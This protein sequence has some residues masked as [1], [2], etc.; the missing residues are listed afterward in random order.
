MLSPL[1]YGNHI[2][3][4][5]VDE[6]AVCAAQSS[7]AKCGAAGASGSHRGQRASASEGVLPA[8]ASSLAL[9]MSALWFPLPS[10]PPSLQH[11]QV[12]ACS[13][14]SLNGC[15]SPSPPRFPSSGGP[16][17][18]VV[19]A[20]WLSGALL[21][22]TAP[23][24]EQ[25]ASLEA[26]CSCNHRD[27]ARCCLIAIPHFDLLQCAQTQHLHLNPLLREQRESG[28]RLWDLYGGFI[29]IGWFLPW[30]PQ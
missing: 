15:L 10:H 1:L 24:Q 16:N 3:L 6:A 11:R 20:L 27:T 8:P 30:F 25:S 29:N 7:P 9:L 28:I 2:S 13:L 4:A 21:F 14:I 26:G 5:H 23:F 22:I 18:D 12:H 19:S 17:A